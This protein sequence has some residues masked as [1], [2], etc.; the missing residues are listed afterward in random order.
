MAQ[1]INTATIGQYQYQVGDTIQ[2]ITT[3]IFD[4][5]TNTLTDTIVDFQKVCNPNFS[6]LNSPITLTY[7]AT[8]NTQAT[9][10]VFSNI[11]V[12]DDILITN[13][14]IQILSTNNVLNFIPATGR[15]DIDLSSVGGGLGPNQTVVA[16][17]TLKLLPGADLT[18]NYNTVATGIFTEPTTGSSNDLTDSC[19]LQINNGTLTIDKTSSVPPTTPVA[20][21]QVLTYTITIRNTGNVPTTILPGNFSD[22]L[23]SGATY[24]DSLSPSTFTFDGTQVTNSVAVTIPPQTNF[25]VVYNVT[26]N[27]PVF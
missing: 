11:S 2:V 5:V 17:V 9:T 27:C 23:P 20:C 18:L 21:G 14:N 7:T 1:V 16:T 15:F 3:P 19:N 10:P 13:P 25:V 22:P 24:A 12:Q 4:T 6:D 26:V 8:N